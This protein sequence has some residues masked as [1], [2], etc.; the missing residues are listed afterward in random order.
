MC[1]PAIVEKITNFRT[2]LGG[3]IISLDLFDSDFDFDRFTLW[4]SLDDIS[5]LCGTP[6]SFLK[7]SRVFNSGV[8]NKD[9]VRYDSNVTK[10]DLSVTMS[11]LYEYN[12]KV[13]VAFFQFVLPVMC[14]FYMEQQTKGDF[15]ISQLPMKLTQF[16][17]DLK[18][19]DSRTKTLE[20]K[21]HNLN[22]QVISLQSVFLQ[23]KN[24]QTLSNKTC[25]DM[26]P[27][28]NLDVS[29]FKDDHVNP[30]DFVTIPEFMAMPSFQK[31]FSLNNAYS[32]RSKL[33][34]MFKSVFTKQANDQIRGEIAKAFNIPFYDAKT[35]LD[36]ILTSWKSP[37]PEKL[38]DIC[39]Q[40]RADTLLT[41]FCYGTHY[42]FNTPNGVQWN[43]LLK[44]PY[45]S[46]VKVVCTALDR[47]WF[48][49]V[50]AMMG[51]MGLPEN[52]EMFKKYKDGAKK[53]NYVES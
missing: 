24:Q 11:L 37:N 43:V 44:Y 45:K 41:M 39:G 18:G 31:L 23:L 2:T 5:T 32:E 1:S 10:Y 16:G 52:H 38:S 50:I 35:L 14:K 9:C 7:A 19:C 25:S 6:V 4:L 26:D 28:A 48:N 42:Q 12:P 33:M 49:E 53:K 22:E 40:H 20:S 15:Q 46:L 30:S 36:K 13:G 8:Y 34:T 21:V 3:K 47:G 27:S 17:I 29:I 51:D